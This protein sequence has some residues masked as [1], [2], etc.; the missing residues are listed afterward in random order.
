MLFIPYGNNM[1]IGRIAEEHNRFTLTI[2]II[3]Y[4][5]IYDTNHLVT[6]SITFHNATGFSL[7]A[8]Q[9]RQRFINDD[10]IAVCLWN[11]VKIPAGFKLH[12]TGGQV[13]RIYRFKKN[14]YMQIRIF[15]LPAEFPGMI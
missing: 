11:A 6:M 13:L 2:Y 1:G 3:V 14:I 4:K 15:S 12:A 9:F 10:M 5:I 8:H 7:C